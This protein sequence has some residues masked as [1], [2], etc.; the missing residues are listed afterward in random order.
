MHHFL[1]VHTVKEYPE[2]QD[3]WLGLWEAV[4]GQTCGDTRW[5]TSYYDPKDERLYCVWEAN[6]EEEIQTCFGAVDTEMAPIEQIRE[7]AYFDIQAMASNRK[8]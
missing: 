4:L 8:E 3:E 2:T 5:L 6:S 7:V 1:V